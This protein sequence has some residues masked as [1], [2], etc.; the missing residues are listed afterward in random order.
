MKK[1]ENR[2]LNWLREKYIH[3]CA[4]KSGHHQDNH[5][6][7][8][9]DKRPMPWNI[10]DGP[11]ITWGKHLKKF[12][13]IHFILKYKI[14]NLVFKLLDKALGKYIDVKIPKFHYNLNMLIFDKSYEDAIDLW[15]EK[16]MIMTIKPGEDP[17]E[18][19]RIY[20]RIYKEGKG[21][22]KLRFMKNLALAIPMNDTAYFEF[23]NILMYTL[24]RNM[25][26]EYRNQKVNHLFYNCPN[27]FDVNY[28]AIS[29]VFFDKR[30]NERKVEIDRMETHAYSEQMLNKGGTAL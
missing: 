13:V 2:I 27:T 7:A 16:Y 11:G 20:K 15:L 22:A 1:K 29:K 26:K 8:F 30:T 12:F 19:K 25:D 9:S 18:M 14:L 28:L 10:Y 23:M 5:E 4:G 21:S 3:W 17:R 24:Y 6:Q